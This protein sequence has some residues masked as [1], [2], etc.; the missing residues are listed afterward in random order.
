M[1][2]AFAVPMD[3]ANARLQSC[4]S[5]VNGSTRTPRAAFLQIVKSRRW[6]AFQML[7]ATI[8]STSLMSCRDNTKPPAAATDAFEILTPP[9]PATPRI[10][11]AKIFGVRPASPVLFQI[12][13]TGQRPLVF[14][15]SGLPAGLNL[16]PTTGRIT[17]VLHEAGRY[18]ITLHASNSAGTTQRILTIVVG[19][20]IALTP[21]MGW[22]SWNAWGGKVSQEKVLAAARA[23]VSSG[24]RDHGWSYINV[25]DGWQGVRGGPFN[26]IQGN[27]KFPDMQR[28]AD[29]VH[30]L[31][32]KLG[33][34]SSPWRT[35]FGWHIGSSA[36]HAD[37]THDWINAAQHNDIFQYLV[38]EYRSSLPRWAWLKPLVD[39][40]RK[41]AQK[42]FTEGMRTFGKFSFVEQDVRQWAAWGVDYLKYDWVPI[43]VPTATTM[44]E[45]LRKTP[46]DIVYTLSNNARPTVA[47]DLSQVANAWRTTIDMQ[48]TW[49]SMSDI[50]FAQDEWA[51]FQR[52]GHYNDPDMLVLGRVMFGGPGPS[53]L[54]ADEQYTHMSL[55][56]L[57]AGPLLIGA[58]LDHLDAFTLGL[59][60]NNEVLDVHQDV[61]CKQAT[62]VRRSGDS[63]VYTK[64]LEDGS[65][66]VGL[67][68]RGE[69]P[70]TVRVRWSDLQL[71]GA[72][73]VRDLWRQQ[74]LGT[75]ADHFE[76]AV[77]RHA[78]RLVR[79]R[80][81]Q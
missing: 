43:D 4:R 49:E 52:P 41:R 30:E 74:D 63:V 73:I 36:D 15:A 6:R 23:M 20:E 10:N 64:A 18:P 50:G 42:R 68:N 13:A 16:D 21:P 29:E 57:L 22:N 60:T 46:R 51:P 65:W 77:P 40:G 78:V 69:K 12:A 14:A 32:L 76:T 28:L 31:G 17:G 19:Q 59:L 47:G 1:R 24:L 58:D 8:A 67:F 72:Q 56:C 44:A 39:R 70:A 25:D 54:T 48:D 2:L 5:Q 62:S 11:G 3:R 81:A 66:A 53:R 75:F 37:G 26:A 45:Q 35:T 79:I 27:R 61:L 80:A 7:F 9:A 34:Y 33:I 71:T 55:W 38:P